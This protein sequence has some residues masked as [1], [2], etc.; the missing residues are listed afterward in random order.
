MAIK[1]C[2]CR[3]HVTGKPNIYNVL[4]NSLM[5]SLRMRDGRQRATRQYITCRTIYIY[6]GMIIV[7]ISTTTINACRG[8][9][10]C[11]T[12]RRVRYPNRWRT[13]RKRRVSHIAFNYSTWV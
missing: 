3:R 8:K 9:K 4:A 12:C 10:L 13:H 1:Q 7:V 2:H 6:I 11:Y 5:Q